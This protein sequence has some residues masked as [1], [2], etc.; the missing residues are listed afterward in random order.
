M[1]F[2]LPSEH[3]ELRFHGELA[4]LV[5]R[6]GHAGVVR[7]PVRRRASIKD[8]AEA[9]GV[10]HT[11][12]YSVMA[13]GKESDLD[14]LLRAGQSVDLRPAQPPVDPLCSTRLRPCPLPELRFVVDENVAGLALLLRALGYDAAYDRTW[15][16]EAIADLARDE[17]RFVLS[18]DRGLLKRSRVIWGRLVRS[19]EPDGQLAEMVRFLGITRAPQPFVR[20]LRCNLI[21]EPVSKGRI[22]H[23]L[24]PRT[25]KYFN[26]F[27]LCRGCNRIYWRGSHHAH[28]KERL[29][30]AGVKIG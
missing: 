20:C 5:R 6:S 25:S 7:Y 16:D 24:E 21:T 29:E 9:L 12:V 22:L 13:E 4:L 30:S 2:E 26:E 8:V 27:R 15:D 14:T 1:S 10:P 18:R 28:L 17:D 11:E 3:A 23:R 19:Q